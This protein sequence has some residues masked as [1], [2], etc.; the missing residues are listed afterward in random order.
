MKTR[1][2]IL[3]LTLASLTLQA[4]SL[5]DRI[6]VY[7]WV[8]PAREPD[9]LTAARRRTTELGLRT[10]RLYL[11]ARYDYQRPYLDPDRFEGNIPTTPAEILNVPRYR[12]VLDDPALS[13]VILTAYS[14]LDYGAGPDDV[15][16]LRPFADREREAVH[17]QMLQLSRLLFTRYGDQ[18][19]TVILANNEADEKLMEIANYTGDP[20]LAVKNIVDWINTR[21]SAVEQAR[22]EFPDARLRL[23]HAFEISVVNLRIAKTGPR[24][25]KAPTQDGI[26][27]LNDVLPDIR[28]DLVSYSSYES[29]NSP[30]ETRDPDSPP[31]QV[32]ARLNRDLDRISR[33]A[34]DSISAFG[35]S[36]FGGEYVMIGEL[37]FARETF[38]RLGGVLPRLYY[39]LDTAVG[40]RCPWIVLWQ[41]FDAPRLGRRSWG[42]G[43]RDDADQTPRLIAPDGGCDSIEACLEAA[44]EH[45][46]RRWKE[47]GAF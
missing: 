17:A 2:A 15:N 43:L 24:Y 47:T 4:Q 22:S 26:S 42:Y 7:Q 13:T 3:G 40:R 5:Q 27:A 23:A 36:E 1:I 44:L 39:A 14:S 45:G 21:Q 25:A 19:K 32:A 6:G 16:L 37:G 46:L 34:A 10:F 11:G 29:V 41:A 28:T 12:E 20:E 33:A 30:F 38:E 8:S 35:R 18:P 9:V 31:R